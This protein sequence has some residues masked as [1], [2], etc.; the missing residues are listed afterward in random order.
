MNKVR[1][2]VLKHDKSDIYDKRKV[3][4]KQVQLV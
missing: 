1:W 3:L 4:E 2:P